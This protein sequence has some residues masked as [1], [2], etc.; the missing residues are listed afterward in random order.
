M[1][2]GLVFV[3]REFPDTSTSTQAFF[4]F[5][6]LFFM[7]CNINPGWQRGSLSVSPNRPEQN[8]LYAVALSTSAEVWVSGRLNS[9]EEI[10]IAPVVHRSRWH[11]KSLPALFSLSQTTTF[12]LFAGEYSASFGA[13]LCQVQRTWRLVSSRSL[14][15][16]EFFS[17]LCSADWLK[18]QIC[19]GL[20]VTEWAQM[21]GVRWR[22]SL[23]GMV[24][25][26]SLFWDF[27]RVEHGHYLILDN[28]NAYLYTGKCMHKQF[29]WV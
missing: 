21:E 5:F 22:Q 4:F 3:L 18:L 26:S 25:Q 9:R 29:C 17:A 20:R 19:D 28:S 16:T 8:L 2:R 24:L 27:K 10:N 1:V 6:F 14:M 23:W 11:C 13:L 15:T 12:V 7:H